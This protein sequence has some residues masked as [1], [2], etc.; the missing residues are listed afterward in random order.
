MFMNMN[1]IL[2][3]N[4]W[5]L[6]IT[7]YLTYTRKREVTVFFFVGVDCPKMVGAEFDLSVVLAGSR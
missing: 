2:F 6:L 1:I 4:M 7:G 3:Y 5:L